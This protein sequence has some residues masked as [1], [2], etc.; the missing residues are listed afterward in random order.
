MV[1]NKQLIILVS[2]I[3]LILSYLY[4]LHTPIDHRVHD[5]W[6]HVDYSMIITR[7]HRFPKPQEGHETYHPPLYYLINTALT[8]KWWMGKEIKIDRNQHVKDVRYLSVLYG[9]LAL[10]IMVWFLQKMKVTSFQGLLILLFIAT[11]PKFMFVFSTYNN[12]SLETLLCMAVIA[13]SYSLYLKWSN[14]L[15][16]VLLIVATAGLYTKYTMIAC[17]VTVSLIT[18]KNL[19][20]WKI[21]NE[22]SIKIVRILILSIILLFPWL[23]FHNYR[24]TGKLFPSNVDRKLSRNFQESIHL[25]T[26]VIKI[27]I[28]QFRE[29]EWDEPWIYPTDG[30]PIKGAH[31]ATKNYDFLSFI[32]VNSIIGE[33]KFHKPEPVFTWII[34]YIQLVVYFFGLRE[35]LRS[36]ICKSSFALL[37][38]SH[39]MLLFYVA[40]FRLPAG[41]NMDYRFIC[42]NWVGLAVLYASAILNNK[43]NAL[44]IFSSLLFFGI[45]IHVY[46]LMTVRGGSFI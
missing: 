46:I 39:L 23:Y 6:G 45:I 37:M 12:D 36:D 2:M 9:E 41:C 29:H 16:I 8:T 21:P 5:M 35:I 4:L 15:G 33:F 34:F 3:W 19:W 32:F 11:T 44:R 20:R 26:Q 24:I 14:K 7:Q 10:L 31:Q 43:S 30:G 22:N 25:L 27:P 28:I 13:L 40:R 1:V 38:F 17:I 42:W 18:L